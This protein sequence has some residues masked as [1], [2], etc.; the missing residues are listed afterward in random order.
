MAD[1]DEQP[2]SSGASIIRAWRISERAVFLEPDPRSSYT[3][4][5]YPRCG[6]LN[7]RNGDTQRPVRTC[8]EPGTRC[9][10]QGEMQ[11]LVGFVDYPIMGNIESLTGSINILVESTRLAGVQP[12]SMS[13]LHQIRDSIHPLILNRG[14]LRDTLEISWPGRQA[15]LYKPL[16]CL[17][18]SLSI[19][20]TLSHF[21]PSSITDRK[22]VV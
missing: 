6:Q 20:V 16:P 17:Q 3:K 1:S 4:Y 18:T 15:Q 13:Y 19:Q 10:G 12:A 9:Q 7:C 21:K 14:G 5:R 2:S 11:S 22:S 8:Q